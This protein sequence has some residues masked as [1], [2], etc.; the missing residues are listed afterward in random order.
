MPPR[1]RVAP[2][3][4]E[5]CRVPMTRRRHPCGTLEKPAD[6]EVRRFCSTRCHREH[7]KRQARR[8]SREWNRLTREYVA[9]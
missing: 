7:R 8:D 6:F 9:A 2:R 3:P 1:M 4:C 5:L